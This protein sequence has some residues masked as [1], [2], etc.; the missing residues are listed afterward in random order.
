MAHGTETR[1]KEV[2]RLLTMGSQIQ[3][4]V[5]QKKDMYSLMM[6]HILITYGGTF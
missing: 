3:S 1:M 4:T 5:I 2:V 6:I